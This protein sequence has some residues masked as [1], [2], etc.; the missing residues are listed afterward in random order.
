MSRNNLMRKL[1]QDHSFLKFCPICNKAYDKHWKVVNH[2]RKTKDDLHQF[3]LKNQE[4]EV[5]VL[6]LQDQNIFIFL[7]NLYKNRN[8][9]SGIAEGH[10]FAIIKRKLNLDSL[11]SFRRSNISKT[12]EGVEKTTEHNK[13]VSKAV[14]KAWRDGVFDT[15][16]YKDAY[17]A[18][19][20]N[21]PSMKGKNNPMYGKPC[22]KG[23]GRGRGGFRK[24]INLYVRS[25]WEANFAR[26]LSFCNINYEY[27]KK[28][29]TL[30]SGLTYSPDFYCKYRDIYYEIKGHAESRS[31]WKCSCKNCEKGKRAI[32]ELQN[33]GVRIKLIG[34][35][36]YNFL[37][38]RFKVH[39][40]RWEK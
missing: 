35:R 25:T 34:H 36:E 29:F 12:M 7:D 3:F 32:K 28:R 17:W 40:K 2:I 38:N 19:R 16:K 39:L 15:K 11:E 22:P 14:K 31:K 4:D 6:Y 37:K 13:N 1:R 27:E 20:K 5:V 10:I 23:A 9:F 26:I 30:S 21:M 24:D 8:I 18:G 33:K